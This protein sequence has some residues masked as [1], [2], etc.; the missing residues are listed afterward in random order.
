MG[1]GFNQNKV[2]AEMIDSIIQQ[3]SHIKSI[4]HLFG[5][6]DINKIVSILEDMFLEKIT[7][8]WA[9]KLYNAIRTKKIDEKCFKKEYEIS[10]RYG[11]FD[12]ILILKI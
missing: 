11:F 8:R 6:S 2:R 3:K 4:E 9:E 5:E 1:T 12:V 7:L 10:A